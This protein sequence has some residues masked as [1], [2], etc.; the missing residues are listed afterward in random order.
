MR[1]G[2][3]FRLWIA[4]QFIGDVNGKTLR[5]V[6]EEYLHELIQLNL[7]DSCGR[8]SGGKVRCCQVHSLVRE[9]IPS[10]AEQENFTS[11]LTSLGQDFC[12]KTRRL[13]LHDVVQFL[14]SC[15]DKDLSLIRTFIVFGRNSSLESLASRLIGEFRLLGVLDLQDVHL[16]A[17]PEGITKLRLQ[18]YLSLRNTKVT[19]IPRS[20][21]NLQN[22]VTLD[23]RQTS[24]S[25]L[26]KKII[27]LQNLL[28]LFVDF[29]DAQGARKGVEVVPGFEH[30]Q[31]LE[32]LSLV[33][34][35]KN[36]L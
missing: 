8:D 25:K 32:K 4:E 14:S 31:W 3:L 12:K 13:I 11:V 16:E 19:S 10:K 33:K 30:L 23:L 5:E 9:F 29:Q 21:K 27:K 28:Y 1:C 35:S 22:L 20:I 7:V 6:A 36:L 17:F 24:I 34:A 18:R 2:R 15:K 26:H